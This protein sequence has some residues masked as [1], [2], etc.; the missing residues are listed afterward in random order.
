[1]K[2]LRVETVVLNIDSIRMTASSGRF[3]SS[4]TFLNLLIV[5]KNGTALVLFETPPHPSPRVL[6][7]LTICVC[8]NILLPVGVG[9]TA[10]S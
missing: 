3:S 4:K 2:N 7:P 6:V 1:M 8:R 5:L 9:E 10:R